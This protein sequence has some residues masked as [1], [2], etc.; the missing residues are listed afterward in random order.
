MV[1]CLLK[2]SVANADD[3]VR[4]VFCLLT[5]SDASVSDF[6]KCPFLSLFMQSDESIGDFVERYVV[7]PC[8]LS[9]GREGRVIEMI[10]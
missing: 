10:I 5:P 9:R 8:S 2:Q 4:V 7:F 6:A 1:F 3:L